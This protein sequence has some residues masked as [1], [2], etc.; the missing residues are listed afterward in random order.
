MSPVA[1]WLYSFK[2]I[3]K[4]IFLKS[5]VFLPVNSFLI[6]S[7]LCPKINF[8]CFYSSPKCRTVYRRKLSM[9]YDLTILA[10]LLKPRKPVFIRVHD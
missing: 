10:Y 6:C 9:S 5:K 4:K 8:L 1:T 2:N 7:E 3:F